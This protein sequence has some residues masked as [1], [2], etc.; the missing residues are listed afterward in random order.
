MES[1][2]FDLDGRGDLV[3]KLE[4]RGVLSRLHLDIKNANTQVFSDGEVCVEDLK[5]KV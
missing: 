5:N 4:A 1:I 3:E 2:L